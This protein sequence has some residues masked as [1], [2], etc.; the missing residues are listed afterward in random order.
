M[1][2]EIIH[3]ERIREEAVAF[4][5][6]FGIQEEIALIQAWVDVWDGQRE[7]GNVRP[8]YI[9]DRED[10]TVIKFE[11]EG[12]SE[13]IQAALKSDTWNKG[14]EK[15]EMMI[16][17]LKESFEELTCMFQWDQYQVSK[18]LTDKL[19]WTIPWY[20]CKTH[21]VEFEKGSINFRDMAGYVIFV[22]SIH[23]FYNAFTTQED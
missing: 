17:E 4:S 9:E 7:Q 3:W 13:Q 19:I 18:E 1:S 15:M 20:D 5:E 6:Q 11:R 14:Q 8:E 10:V 21:T 12:V 23:E 16:R 22:L 2:W